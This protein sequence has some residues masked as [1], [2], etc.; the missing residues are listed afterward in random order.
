VPDLASKTEAV[1]LQ[2]SAGGEGT[3]PVPPSQVAHAPPE[4]AGKLREFPAVVVPR[5]TRARLEYTGRRASCVLRNW[6]APPTP[7]PPPP[8][9]RPKGQWLP[10][11]PLRSVIARLPWVEEACARVVPAGA[12]EDA[13][14]WEGGGGE[15]EAAAL[16]WV[17][18]AGQRHGAANRQPFKAFWTSSDP[19]PL[20]AGVS[21]DDATPEASSSNDSRC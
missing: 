16:A 1:P 18:L 7:P 9:Q 5:A 20:P 21:P 13:S 14:A 8:P 2:G 19:D 12:C 4:P 17:G 15:Q 11:Q 10:R 6:P 3:R